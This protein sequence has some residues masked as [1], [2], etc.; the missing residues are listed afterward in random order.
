MEAAVTS[1]T[2][3]MG[4][5][6]GQNIQLVVFKLGNDEYALSIDAI[7]EVVIT[8]A[9]TRV[10]L[11]PK[12]IRGVAN[13]R[14]TILAIVD[15]EEKLSIQQSERGIDTVK[16]NFLLVIESEDCKMGILV[17]EVP[18]TLSVS[19]EMIDNSPGLLQESNSEKGYVK[20]IAKVNN[21]LIV[22]VDVFKF[23]SKEDITVH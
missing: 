13:V 21:R 15:L 14:G 3:V 16:Q 9:I 6:A 23:V 19:P 20:G 10:P 17:K 8:P 18:N 4:K 7:K 5:N 22:L 12:H 11:A 1:S 2:S